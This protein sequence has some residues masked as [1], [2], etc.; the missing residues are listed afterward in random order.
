MGGGQVPVDARE[1]VRIAF[2]QFV[3]NEAAVRRLRNDLLRALIERPP[4]LSKNY[5]ITGQPSTGKTELARRMATALGLPFVRLDGRGVT[6]RERLFDLIG[7]ELRQQGM[8]A[9]HVGHQASLR[10]MQYPPLI[11]FIDEV[12]LVPRAIQESFLTMLEAADRSVTLVNQ[13]A[14]MDRATFIFATTR[15]SELDPAFRSRCTEIQLREYDLA[16]VAEIVRQRFPYDW[17]RDIYLT[18]ARVGRRVPRVAIEVARELETEIAVSE[19][20]LSRL[21]EHLDEVRKAR[22]VD[23]LGVGRLDVEYLG[24]LDRE[25]RPL[26]EQAILNMLGNVDRDRVT[27]EVEPFL[28]RLGFIR[29]GARGREVTPEGRQYLLVRRRESAP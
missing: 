3:G 4:Y 15:A 28:I 2:A 18:I 16:E 27:E 23:Q 7:G 14:K 29:R 21:E 25:N 11:V 20:P 26:G 9:S 13:V 19:Q 5:L 17:P 10:V 12:H 8:S 22:E 1:R 6:S 24:L